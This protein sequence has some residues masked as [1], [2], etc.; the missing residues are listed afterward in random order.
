MVFL[1][2]KTLTHKVVINKYYGGMGLSN[3]AIELLAKR[4][5]IS[6]I[7]IR[8]RIDLVNNIPRHDKDLV[9]I[10]EELGEKANG[11]FASLDIQTIEGNKYLIIDYD[12]AEEIYTPERIE[13][14]WTIIEEN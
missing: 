8:D 5:N 11:N 4:K 10:V 6:L 7:T 14:E 13:K 3:E 1:K 2:E 9:D 12:G